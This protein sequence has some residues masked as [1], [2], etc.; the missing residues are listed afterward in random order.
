MS[1]LPHLGWSSHV[2]PLEAADFAKVPD[3]DGGDIPVAALPGDDVVLLVRPDG[4]DALLRGRAKAEE[5]AARGETVQVRVVFRPSIAKWNLPA[6]IVRAL[7]GK[8]RY[9]GT[10]VYHIAPQAIRAMGLERAVRTLDNPQQRK[11]KDRAASMKRLAASLRERGY[12]DARP[13]SV[14]LC[15]IFGLRDSLR[16]GHHRISAC[17]ECGIERMA[18]GFCAAGAL[19][20]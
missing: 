15:R 3:Y 11:N 19:P 1:A 6:T 10:G 14:H 12:D 17:L 2:Y 16:Q 9:H 8:Y 20:R 18:M 13:I 5:A 4:P 7:R